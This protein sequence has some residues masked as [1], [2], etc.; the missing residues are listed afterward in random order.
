MT[1]EQKKKWDRIGGFVFGVLTIAF[2]LLMA[3]NQSFFDW[4]W[5]RHHNEWSWYV[6]SVSLLPFIY[7]AYKRSFTGMTFSIFALTTSM[8]WFPE[9]AQV[10]ENA[11]AFLAMEEEYLFSAW[12][13][14][15]IGLALT[16][17]LMFV[18]LAVAFWNRNFFYGGVVIVVAVVTKIIWSLVEGGQSGWV[19]VP[20]AVIGL[21]ITLG[22][23]YWGYRR[24]RA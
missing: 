24:Q 16:I 14:Y 2:A 15:K 20:T 7:F 6:R 22:L 10:S 13:A 1:D 5:G 12:N 21:L 4:A 19:L 23:I 18:L 11:L 3:L 8:A 17:P 9:P